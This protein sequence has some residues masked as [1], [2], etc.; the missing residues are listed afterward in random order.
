MEDQQS[1]YNFREYIDYIYLKSDEKPDVD[2]VSSVYFKVL[3]DNDDYLGSIRIG[4]LKDFK[5]YEKKDI[6]QETINNN[7][8][9]FGRYTIEGL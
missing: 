3:D 6:I 2:I 9:S 7:Y 4:F 5:D 1:N 8:L